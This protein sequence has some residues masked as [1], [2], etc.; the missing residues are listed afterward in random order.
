M[1]VEPNEEVLQTSPVTEQPK[2]V[3]LFNDIKIFK[4]GF[5]IFRFLLPPIQTPFTPH[6]FL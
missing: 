1:G 4:H 2:A 5:K 6:I 3:N